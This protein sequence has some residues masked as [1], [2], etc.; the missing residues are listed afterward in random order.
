MSLESK[1]LLSREP[2]MKSSNPHSGGFPL[3][4]GDGGLLHFKASQLAFFTFTSGPGGH[5]FFFFFFSFAPLEK[6][7]EL[8]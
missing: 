6:S 1:W 5:L 7:L 3:Q 8:S 4:A 2:Q